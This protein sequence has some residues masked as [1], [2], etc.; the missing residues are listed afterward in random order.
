MANVIR[1]L[2]RS[3]IVQRLSRRDPVLSLGVRFSRNADIARMAWG[4]GYDVIWIDLEHSSMTVDNAAA[5]AAAATD[6]GLAAWVRVPEREYGMIGRVLDCG[7]V[8]IIAPKIE[9]AEE[10]Q[11]IAAACRFPPEGKR[12]M[13]AV[14][15]QYGFRRMPVAELV[16]RSNEAMTVQIIIE[17]AVGVTNVDAIAAVQGIDLIA[18]GMNDLSSD[19]GCPGVTDHPK[20]LA[21]CARV[22]AA[23]A[24]HGKAAVIGG[25]PAAQFDGFLSNG[26]SPLIFAGIDTDVMADGLTLRSREW[27]SRMPSDTPDN[28]DTGAQQS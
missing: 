10:A 27:R 14:V 4:A 12:S 19:L 23:A 24:R 26:Y 11:L 7:A 6:L 20:V 22:A 28:T 17:S 2:G 1:P 13:L 15:P 16:Q 3:A 9:T 21:A 25:V 5:I 18:V 8:G